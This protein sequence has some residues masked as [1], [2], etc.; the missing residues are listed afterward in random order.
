[1]DKERV[2]RIVGG[3]PCA[4]CQPYPFL[5]LNSQR[6]PSGVIEPSLSTHQLE[7]LRAAG[8]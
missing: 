8:S 5:E 7:P 3:R 6:L 2:G 1:M 4:G